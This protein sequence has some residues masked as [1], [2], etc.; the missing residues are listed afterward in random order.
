MNH[1]CVHNYIHSAIAVLEMAVVIAAVVFVY[2]HT[3]PTALQSLPV[4]LVSSI[5]DLTKSAPATA[6]AGLPNA[7]LTP[8]STDPRVTQA[9]IQSTI[10]RKGG[11][12]S[13]VRPPVS[14]TEP[15]KLNGIKLY[16]Y[17]DRKASDY[18]EDHLIPLELGGNPTDPR[19]L[20]PEPHHIGNWG[21][22]VKDN[23]ENRLRDL[24]CSGRLDLGTAQQAIATDWIAAYKKYMGN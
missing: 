2:S 19:N 18:E 22:Y 7:R 10:C 21:S 23:L 24:V 4:V 16:G 12:T 8:G 9:N 14:Y 17:S 20:W 11:Y 15:L 13:S 3:L 6:T 5:S 1:K